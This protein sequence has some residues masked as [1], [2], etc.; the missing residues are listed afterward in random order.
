MP[1]LTDEGEVALKE[2][3]VRAKPGL[4]QAAVLILANDVVHDVSQQA[5]HHQ[6]LHVVALPAVL[7]VGGNLCS[8]TTEVRNKKKAS[9]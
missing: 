2:L 4:S 8:D 7:Q 5:R 6:D 1:G 9:S 3:A